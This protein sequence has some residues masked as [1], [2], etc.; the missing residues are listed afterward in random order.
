MLAHGAHQPHI[1]MQIVQSEQLPAL[2]L[3]HAI[4]MKQISDGVGLA[5]IAGTC[6]IDRPLHALIRGAPQ[7]APAETGECNPLPRQRRRQNAIEHIDAAMHGFEQIAGRAHSHEISRPILGQPLGHGGRAVLARRH[8]FA[9]REAADGKA[10]EGQLGN[11]AR[12]FDPQIR[13]ARSLHDPEQRL[14]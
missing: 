4:E 3:M 7:I 12:A 9:H 8:G 6:G 10:V 5:G 2:G 14:R 13:V 11:G 1:E